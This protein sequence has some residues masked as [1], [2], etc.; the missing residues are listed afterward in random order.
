MLKIAHITNVIDGRSNSGT[1]RVASQL[2]KELS[3]RPN[4]HQ[5][6]IHFEDSDDDIYSLP[7]T[8]EVLMPLR[9]MRY[10]HHFRSF[11]RFWISN[12]FRGKPLRFDIVHWHSSRVFPFFFL[13]PSNKTI[14]TLYDAGNRLMQGVNTFSTRVFY[15]NL[16]LSIRQVDLILG[17]SSKAAKDL[18]VAG[19][20]PE[21]KVEF[22]YCGSNFSKITPRNVPDVRSPFIVC[23]ARWQPFKN[24]ESVVEGYGIATRVAKGNLPQLV[25]VG[26]PVNGHDLPQVKVRSLGL[27]HAVQ[28]LQDLSDEELAYL[29]DFAWLNMVPSLHEGFGLIVLEGLSRGCTPVVHKYTA[30]AEIAG[31]CGIQV[32][33]SSPKQIAEVILG[34]RPRNIDLEVYCRQR[35]EQFTWANSAD[36]LMK[37]YERLLSA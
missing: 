12:L 6:L 35:A 24:V 16:R 37:I 3:T 36:K 1:A 23:I 20:F 26:K 11:V 29:L 31:N 14:I 30:T 13:I 2:I 10:G 33:M 7:N 9:G 25:L 21:N 22:V 8:T 19:K 15:W 27:E 34:G 5:Y 17:V 28:I 4:V 32:D 18:V